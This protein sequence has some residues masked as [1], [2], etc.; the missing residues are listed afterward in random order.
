MHG[1]SSQDREGDAWPLHWQAWLSS[2]QEPGNCKEK[3][4]DEW[5]KLQFLVL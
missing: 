5:D 4:K 1:N 2:L 3:D